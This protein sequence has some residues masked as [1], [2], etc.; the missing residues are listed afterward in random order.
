VSDLS[1]PVLSCTRDRLCAFSIGPGTASLLMIEGFSPIQAV[2]IAVLATTGAAEVACCLAPPAPGSWIRARI[3]IVIV[4]LVVIVCL[5]GLGYPAAPV[6]VGV[7]ACAWCMAATARRIT[8]ARYR[9]PQL[10]VGF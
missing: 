1:N 6:L 3:V 5:L 2:L 10:R 9:L 4:I 8:G 7:L